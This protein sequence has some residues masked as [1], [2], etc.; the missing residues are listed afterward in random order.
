MH[1]LSLIIALNFKILFVIVIIWQRYLF[2]DIAIITVKEVDY[3]CIIHD[4]SKSEAIHLLENSVLDD[5]GY[6]Y[7]WMSKKSILKLKIFW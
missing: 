6:T 2:S 4:V 3:H 5:R 7:K 1:S